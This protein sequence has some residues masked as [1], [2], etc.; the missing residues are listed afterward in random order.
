MHLPFADN[1]FDAVTISYGLRNIYDPTAALRESP[2][3]PNPAA[4]SP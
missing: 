2:A 3:S 1:T 4:D